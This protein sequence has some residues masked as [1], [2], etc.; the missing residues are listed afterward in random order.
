MRKYLAISFFFLNSF[1]FAYY[2][3]GDTISIEDQSYPLNV[4]YGDYPD[5]IL[6]LSDFNGDSNGGDYKV[7]VFRMT[8]TW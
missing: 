7:I 6:R 8:A 5:G 3:Y 2:Q 4:C 1:L